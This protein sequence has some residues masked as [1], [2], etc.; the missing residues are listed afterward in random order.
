MRAV[1]TA[2]RIDPWLRA[3]GEYEYRVLNFAPNTPR[4]QARRVL[5]DEAERGR[6]EMSRSAIYRGGGRRVWLRRKT[7]TVTSTLF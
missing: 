6:W 7:L 2:T 5:T 4:S 3:G 1:T